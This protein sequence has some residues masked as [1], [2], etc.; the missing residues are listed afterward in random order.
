MTHQ[1]FVIGESGLMHR[2]VKKFVFQEPIGFLFILCEL[3]T[4]LVMKQKRHYY[5]VWSRE[6]WIYTHSPRLLGLSFPTYF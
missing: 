2:V 1:W 5:L 4:D 3:N 6:A